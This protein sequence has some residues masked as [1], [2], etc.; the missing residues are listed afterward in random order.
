MQFVKVKEKNKKKYLN[1]CANYLCEV[2]LFKK[3]I[4]LKFIV[5]KYFQNSI[6]IG[7]KLFL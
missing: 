7:M 4:I 5:R 1:D 3:Y 6:L 2:N